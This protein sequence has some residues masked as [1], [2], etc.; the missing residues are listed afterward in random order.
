MGAGLHKRTTRC[1][2]DTCGLAILVELDL[3]RA[4]IAYH[5]SY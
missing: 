4:V 2:F 5:D 3:G 1:N